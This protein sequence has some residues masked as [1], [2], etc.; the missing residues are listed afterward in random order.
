MGT[1][2]SPWMRAAPREEEDVDDTGTGKKRARG[3]FGGG[4]ER[5]SGGKVT[6]EEFQWAYAAFWSRA[7]SLPVL[8]VGGDPI[9]PIV[10]AIVPGIDF[11]NHSGRSAT[12]RW[13]VA[14]LDGPDPAVQLLCEPRYVPAPGSEVFISY[15]EKS[16]EELLFLY[17]FVAGAY[18]RQLFGST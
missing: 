16:N 7:L 13:S 11:A 14:G 1:S 12:A 6:M 15:G 2:V 9:A 10:E 4:G 18:T 3:W 5:V 8:P 17:G